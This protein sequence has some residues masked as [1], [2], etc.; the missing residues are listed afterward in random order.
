MSKKIMIIPV[1]FLAVMMIPMI[2][3]TSDADTSDFTADTGE[4]LTIPYRILTE[5][6][7]SAN[8]TVMTVASDTPYGGEPEPLVIPGVVEIAS[9]RYN[10]VEIGENS[11]SGWNIDSVTIPSEVRY[12]R[13]SAFYGCYH[14]KEIH[15][16]GSPEMG[17]N[18]FCLGINDK[19]K[20]EC[21]VYGFTPTRAVGEKGDPYEDIFGKY[22]TVKYMDVQ[23]DDK[24]AIIHIALISFGVLALLYMGRSV[25]VKRIKRRKVRK[26]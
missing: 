20:A 16:N 23:L 2:A 11:F 13:A 1:L 10:V 25:K 26:R 21:S 8:G 4:G 24:D 17:E 5:P 14:V 19:F 3:E 22:T 7:G 15:L 9:K 18:A 12:I 6:S